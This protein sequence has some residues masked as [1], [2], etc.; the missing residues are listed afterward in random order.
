[1]VQYPG[2]PFCGNSNSALSIVDVEID[3]I[4]LK[5]IQCNNCKKYIGFF[6][7]AKSQIDE[8]KEQIESLESDISD[9]EH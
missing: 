3:G 1:M 7:D 8:L 4:V 9:L 6:Q 2:C 5:G